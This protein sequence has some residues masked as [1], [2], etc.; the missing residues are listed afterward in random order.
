MSSEQ[1]KR[2][3]PPPEAAGYERTDAAVGP[4]LRAG[5]ALLAAMFLVSMVVV[6]LYWFFARR[7]TAAQPERATVL[8]AS[9]P[10]GAFPRLVESEPRALAEFRAKEDA[11]LGSYGW[12][13]EDRSLAR[14]PIDEAVRIVGQRG[15]LPAFAAAA[16]P[17]EARP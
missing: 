13:D 3:V 16:P 4:T 10:P 15:T 14:M 6:P 5:V 9:P 8:K 1:P 17:S 2:E 7:E 11:L 12:I